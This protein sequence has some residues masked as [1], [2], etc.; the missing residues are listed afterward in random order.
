MKNVHLLKISLLMQSG[1]GIY[2]T[3]CSDDSI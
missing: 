3:L 1:G 2:A